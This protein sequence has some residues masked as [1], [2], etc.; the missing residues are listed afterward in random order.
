M[1]RKKKKK[2]T[3]RPPSS[4]SSS[5]SSPLRFVFF[6]VASRSSIVFAADSP[7]E[8][9]Q[10][11][12]LFAD[13]PIR[14]F[15]FFIRFLFADSRS[16][17]EKNTSQRRPHHT[18]EAFVA[19]IR[20]SVCEKLDVARRSLAPKRIGLALPQAY[21][22]APS[23]NRAYVMAIEKRTITVCFGR[24]RSASDVELLETL[25]RIG[26]TNASSVW[27]GRRCDVF[28]NA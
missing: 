20:Q 12:V 22:P 19:P 11:R 18:E 6:I 7:K 16:K 13:S 27:C 23:I 21:A 10:N 9:G 3:P 14:R 8:R 25:C 4:I 2:T 17:R 26:A 28:F 15:V 1:P 5:S 24:K